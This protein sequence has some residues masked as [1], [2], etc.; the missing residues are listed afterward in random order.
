MWQRSTKT[1]YLILSLN[2]CRI[3]DRTRR[4][5]L[6]RRRSRALSATDHDDTHPLE[7]AFLDSAWRVPYL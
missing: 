7:A 1:T 4:V 5:Q 6:A 3:D 2:N